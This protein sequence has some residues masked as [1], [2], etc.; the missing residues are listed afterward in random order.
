MIL[1]KIAAVPSLAPVALAALMLSP[2]AACAQITASDTD[3]RA[4]RTTDRI[5][6][7]L[8]DA[9]GVPGMGA[10]VWH[11]GEI[12]WTGAAGHRNLE[13]DLPVN[14]NTVFRLASVSKLFAATSAARLRERGVLDVEAPLG[15]IVGYLPDRWPTIT[16]SQ[17]AAHTAGIPHYQDVDANRGGRRFT[18]VREA[19]AL[20]G[21]RDLLAAPGAAYEYSSWGYVLITAVIEES[22]GQPYLDY[23][24]GTITP[25]LR[26]GPDA[27]DTNDPDA[28]IAYEFDEEGSVRR[29]APHDYSYGWG[30]AGLGGTAPDLARWGGRVL[31]GDI[32]SADTLEWMLAPTLLNDGS[33]VRNGDYPVGFGWRGGHDGD[34]DRIAHHAGVTNGARSVL[35]LYPDRALAVSVLSNALWVSAIDQ[36]AMMIA[37]PFKSS[38]AHSGAVPCPTDAVAYEGEYDGAPLSGSASFRLE[39]GICVG[40]VGVDNAFGAWLNSFPQKDASTLQIIGLDPDGGLGRAALVTPI[41]VFDLRVGDASGRHV[42]ALSATRAFSMT[43][44]SQ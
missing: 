20:F 28:S 35:L 10:A 6:A 38:A 11:E 29:A 1:A 37:A 33:T 15:S 22:V 24:A 16:T 43:L 39:D 40:Q 5:L 36:T 30:G 27:T 34:G 23:L 3:T 25:G 9:N 19:V 17:L 2:Q 44:R 13:Q 18:S 21:D 8:I 12:A 32:V 7:A 42:A 4:A 31:A 26:I 14:A 41:G